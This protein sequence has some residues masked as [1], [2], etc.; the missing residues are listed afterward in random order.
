MNYFPG[1]EMPAPDEMGISFVGSCPWP[2]P[3]HRSTSYGSA[4]DGSGVGD[5]V[6]CR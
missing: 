4:I 3:L 2:D 6:Q 1:S 5:T